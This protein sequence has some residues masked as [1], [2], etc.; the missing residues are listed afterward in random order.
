MKFSHKTS[1]NI[2]FFNSGVS[3]VTMKINVNILDN[4]IIYQ[5]Q[6]CVYQSIHIDL[7]II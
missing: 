4:M 6:N 5:I 7:I 1:K 3:K 2:K